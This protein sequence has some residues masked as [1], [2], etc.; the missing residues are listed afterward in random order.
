MKNWFRSSGGDREE[1]GYEIEDLVVLGRYEEAESRLRERLRVRPDDLRAQLLLADVCLRTGRREEAAE[2]YLIT[3]D[4]YA[5]DGFHDRAVA[6][7]AKTA[8]LLPGNKQIGGKIEELREAKRRE[9]RRTI[10]IR[11]LLTG[12]R[13]A[14]S[15]AGTS[16]LEIEQLWNDLEVSPVLKALD[17]EQLSR[18]FGLGELHRMKAGETLV[19]EGEGLE[20]A[21]FVLEGEIVCETPGGGGRYQELRRFAGGDLLGERAL[22]ERQPWPARY[23]VFKKSF[24]L[25]LTRNGLEAA[26]EG[27]PDPR[28]FLGA[29]RVQQHDAEVVK[30][31]GFLRGEKGGAA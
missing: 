28:G 16:A 2:R 18:F 5:E 24:V 26:L 11:S 7:L 20:A 8:K 4:G 13:G 17:V 31:V 12:H 30:M 6:I 1:E 23:R 27:N 3:S 14:D 15:Q 22:L 29:L 19:H 25:T 9:D 10:A 21:F